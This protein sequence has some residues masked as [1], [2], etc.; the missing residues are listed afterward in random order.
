MGVARKPRID[1]VRRRLRI[2]AFLRENPGRRFSAIARGV[3]LALHHGTSPT[4]ERH[5]SVLQVEGLV[6]QD[7]CGAWWPA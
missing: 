4:V 7:D 1:G 2:L 6:L 3:G 5:L